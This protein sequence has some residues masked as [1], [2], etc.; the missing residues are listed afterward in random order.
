LLPYTIA[1][2]SYP[3]LYPGLKFSVYNGYFNNDLYAIFQPS[4]LYYSGFTTNLADLTTTLANYNMLVPKG[5]NYFSVVYSGKFRCP[6]SGSWV[7][8]M[9]C[10]NAAY[11][12]IDS[13]DGNSIA[14]YGYARFG[15][16]IAVTPIGSG[17]ATVTMTAG[18]YYSIR[19]IYG[20]QDGGYNLNVAFRLST[21]STPITDGTGYYYSNTEGLAV[22]VY[23]NYD[24]PTPASYSFDPSNIVY[25]GNAVDFTNLVT[26]I[27]NVQLPNNGNR[28]AIVY[29]GV[30]NCNSTGSW[31]WTMS[32]T[33]SSA[34]LWIGQ[35]A[36]SGYTISP[37][38][39]TLQSIGN[40]GPAST[41]VYM[42]SGVSYFIRIIYANPGGFF[43]FSLS[44]T[45]P[46]T[47]ATP[48]TNGAAYYSRDMTQQGQY[49]GQ[50]MQLFKIAATGL[51]TN[52]YT[53]S[54]YSSTLSLASTLT[55]LPNFPVPGLVYYSAD[56]SR[57]D[58]R[59][60]FTPTTPWPPTGAAL[61]ITDQNG[62][63][64]I[65]PLSYTTYNVLISYNVLSGII[66]PYVY[67]LQVSGLSPSQYFS[68]TIRG[69]SI[70]VYPAYDF[71]YPFRSFTFTNCG[72]TGAQGPTADAIASTYASTL[73]Y[74]SSYIFT[75][76]E[77]LPGYQLWVVPATGMYAY[78]VAG[79]GNYDPYFNCKC[80][81]AVLT[82]YIG[83]QRGMVI[84]LAVGQQGQMSGFPYYSGG[85]GAS[86]IIY[87]AD[88]VNVLTDF[89]SAS[90]NYNVDLTATY[91]IMANLLFST[92]PTNSFLVVAGGG[93]GLGGAFSYISGN[94]AIYHSDAADII[95]HG[96]FI[97]ILGHRAQCRG[98][99]GD[100]SSTAG[101][102]GGWT[103][104]STPPTTGNAISP[105][106]TNAP[107]GFGCGIGGTGGVLEGGFGG[108]GAVINTDHGAGGG[109]GGFI[110]GNG[111][112]TGTVVGASYG[113]F[114]YG[115]G[116]FWNGA[117]SV[118]PNFIIPDPAT[119][120][121]TNTGMGYI[122]LTLPQGPAVSD[123]SL[124][125]S[126]STTV[127]ASW[128]AFNNGCTAVVLYLYS[129]SNLTSAV[130][131]YPELN[132]G[133][134]GANGTFAFGTNS[135]LTRTT[136][137]YLKIV[138]FYGSPP[139]AYN[140]GALTPSNA[141]LMVATTSFW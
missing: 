94:D 91:P 111:G 73:F 124:T 63:S 27:N 125:S 10:D 89:K 115:G 118:Y 23:T 105:L 13:D 116:C 67:C 16:S 114:G 40:N 15:S 39:C 46:G 99:A 56:S 34:Y 7:W 66:P 103:I 97:R 123:V 37:S 14:D 128:G 77:L 137:Y 12:W 112:I 141:A 88:N 6:T 61:S 47:G 81:G 101:G 64:A 120:S 54:S 129:D 130:S 87:I 35:Y 42:T 24:G 96:R 26:S 33:T 117:S 1:T 132:Q 76:Y 121:A 119:F 134:T 92:D 41:T 43:G 4:N 135:P 100:S 45:P 59:Y 85:A 32:S 80:N 36:Y 84:G 22:T 31:T 106:P 65:I 133:V 57:F 48:I 71:L 104:S 5:T 139:V 17:T 98:Y 58:F 11:L 74:N 21:S 55:A 8:T 18:N 69:P 19:I 72:A 20:Q 122:T 68:S 83:L 75:D 2:T 82:G 44:F 25:T 136:T 70:T 53:S 38:N 138:P 51:D 29:Y 62:N 90:D 78:T 9:N 93:G 50:N 107:N 113:G 49:S 95:H 3:E 60:T 79:A 108:G 86:S 52:V 102:G 127:T 28:F 30:F 140:D 126:S 131:Q 109:G 110:G